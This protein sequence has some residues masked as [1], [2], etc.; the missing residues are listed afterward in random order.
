MTGTFL[1]RFTAFLTCSWK[2]MARKQLSKLCKVYNGFPCF[3]FQIIF[4]KATHYMGKCVRKLKG[5]SNIQI[6][7]LL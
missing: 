3:L 4:L 1:T 2:T 5:P 7:N 6:K